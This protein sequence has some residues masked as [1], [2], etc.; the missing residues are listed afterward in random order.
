MARKD[1]AER[2]GIG[3]IHMANDGP[4]E[5][6]GKVN[7]NTR[8]IRF[9]ET[10][11]EVNTIYP[12][13]IAGSIKDRLRPTVAGVGYLGVEDYSKHPEYKTIKRRWD[14][15]IHNSVR[16]HHIVPCDDQ[17]FAIYF[18]KHAKNL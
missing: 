5:V 16:R 6:I 12:C 4:Y 15:M 1:K 17:C 11:Y 18:E 14:L 10:G 9:L 13:M 3:T 8:R 2:Y 7:W